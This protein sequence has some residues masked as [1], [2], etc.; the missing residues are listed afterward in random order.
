MHC[1]ERCHHD[2]LVIDMM[3]DLG[4]ELGELYGE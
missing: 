1:D 4:E 3:S 2:Q